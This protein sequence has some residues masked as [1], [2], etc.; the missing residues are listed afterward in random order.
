MDEESFNFRNGGYCEVTQPVGFSCGVRVCAATMAIS[1]IGRE[2]MHTWQ[3][4]LAGHK[5]TPACVYQKWAVA[6]AAPTHTMGCHPSQKYPI[7]HIYKCSLTFINV[8]PHLYMYTQI[9]H[10]YKCSLTFINVGSHL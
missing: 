10:I 7:P 6:L 2:H 5:R 8:D 9:A 4:S 3:A 1:S